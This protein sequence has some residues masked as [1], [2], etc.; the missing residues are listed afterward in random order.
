M[1]HLF[2]L[3][4][5]AGGGRRISE[6]RAEILRVMGGQ[7]EPWELYETLGSGDAIRKVREAA[8]SREALR[9]YAC[10]GDGT[11][12]ECVN[13]AVEEAHVAVTHFPAGTGNDFIKTFHAGKE[14][15][16][17]LERFLDPEVMALDVID[18]GGRYGVNI[19]SVGLDA[20][21]GGDVHKYSRLPF[22][23]GKGAYFVSLLVN[24]LRGIAEPFELEVGGKIS[25]EKFTM[26]CLCNGR[27]YGGAFTPVPEALPDDGL[28]DILLVG[29]VSRP[30]VVPLVGKYAAGRYRELPHLITHLQ[31]TS[32]TIRADREF[33]VNVDGEILWRREVVFT[34]L[35]CGVNFFA[36]RGASFRTPNLGTSVEVL[37]NAKN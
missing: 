1:K 29:K 12:N 24:V 26:I 30:G 17:Y 6:V 13:G 20:R 19:C 2:I 33:V 35:P 25:K 10:G 7:G 23:R 16:F 34:L 37:K 9:V 14:H 32:L 36:P 18:A 4:P 11:L 27:S 31:D 5:I 21:I 8:G 22:V 28:M 3:N 15:F